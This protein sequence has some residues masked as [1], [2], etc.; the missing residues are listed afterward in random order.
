MSAIFAMSACDFLVAATT[1]RP[2]TLFSKQPKLKLHLSSGR[3]R[4]MMT[5]MLLLGGGVDKDKGEYVYT[6]MSTLDTQY[7]WD[8]A[9]I[10]T[11]LQINMSKR[12]TPISF[13]LPAFI[14][15]CSKKKSDRDNELKWSVLQVFLERSASFRRCNFAK[16]RIG[17]PGSPRRHVWKSAVPGKEM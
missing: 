8:A 3:L 9:C 14:F 16:L 5:M 6:S 4:T 1:A 13:F 2:K 7:A 12:L 11:L 17:L 15:M 10:R